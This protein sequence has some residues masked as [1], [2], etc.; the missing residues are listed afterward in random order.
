MGSALCRGSSS[1]ASAV[2]PEEKP[3]TGGTREE[4]ARTASV[5][6]AAHGWEEDAEGASGR[7]D[8]TASDEGT[9]PA[10]SASDD[11]SGESG[12][13]GEAGDGSGAS[14]AAAAA[15]D[16]KEEEEE[17]GGLFGGMFDEE[18]DG[19]EAA[20]DEAKVEESGDAASDEGGLFGGMFDEEEE[21]AEGTAADSTA[22][23]AAAAEP[24]PDTEPAGFVL[25][26]EDESKLQ[27]LRAKADVTPD[28]ELTL[29]E[30]IA[31]GNARQV[32]KLLAAGVSTDSSHEGLSA[33][34]VASLAGEAALVK[35]FVKAG[36][37]VSDCQLSRFPLNVVPLL[38]QAQQRQLGAVVGSEEELQPLRKAILFDA[39]ERGDSDA[40]ELVLPALD[41]HARDDAGKLAVEVAASSHH[42]RVVQQL[43]A[44]GSPPPAIDPR[45]LS[46]KLRVVVSKAQIAAWGKDFNGQ[47]LV[48]DPREADKV[49]RRAA[50]KAAKEAA[51]ADAKRAAEEKSKLWEGDVAVEGT[52]RMRRNKH[53]VE[54]EDDM[55]QA[56]KRGDEAAVRRYLA[57]G[58]AFDSSDGYGR[59]PLY[60]AAFCGSI[61]CTR[62]LLVAGARDP[63]GTVELGAPDGAVRDLLNAVARGRDPATL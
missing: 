29:F 21:A 38:M 10:A 31:A 3:A 61:P 36:A 32:K 62:L 53:G 43:L 51:A 12:D 49:A 8:V 7:A 37:D 60:Y 40:I 52:E 63:D 45:S 20:G 54:Y 6:P 50:R 44:A 41:V 42:V 13:D 56:C 48:A 2:A 59:T 34:Q 23:T 19:E 57:A 14:T 35:H 28:A 58:D 25:A 33:L 26:A 11:G 17:D 4:A 46:R 15:A 39:A 24:E 1:T 18:E 30:A 5:A 16:G 22:A 27:D 47:S 55:W 9:A